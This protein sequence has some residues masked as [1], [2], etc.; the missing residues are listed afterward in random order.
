VD[1]ARLVRETAADFKDRAPGLKLD[2]PESL[3]LH[4]DKRRLQR[5]VQNLLANAFNHGQPARGPVALRLFQAGGAACLTVVDQ[6]PGLPTEQLPR[7]FT[8][9][10]SRRQFPAPGSA[11]ASDSACRF[12]WA[13][14]APM[15]AI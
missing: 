9:F 6:G 4:G 3:A 5:L 13:W 14:P 11:A 7:L 10:F 12:A 2:A 8:P 1:L 15:A